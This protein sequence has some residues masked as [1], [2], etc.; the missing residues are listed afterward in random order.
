MAK[1][2][3]RSRSDKVIA[4]VCGGLAKHWETDVVWI[5]VLAVVSIFL[6]GL[7]LL[8]YIIMWIV[9]PLEP[10]SSKQQKVSEKEVVVKKSKK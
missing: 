5:R 6:N 4:G 1:K 9:V 7:G 3:Y 2:L 10:V 8:A